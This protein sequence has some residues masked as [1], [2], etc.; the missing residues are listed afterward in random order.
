MSIL[1]VPH[2]AIIVVA[3][4][5]GTRLE[6][7]A[8]KA[9]V[10]IDGRT[11]LRHALDGVFA[12]AP[13]QVVVVAPAGYEGDAQTELLAAAGDRA[14]LGRVVTGGATRQES[15]AAGL[16]ALWGDVS[17]VLVHDAARA[18]TPP[19]VIDAVA[20]A[21]I[22]DAGA[23]PS[24]P[25]VDTLKRVADGL[26]VGTVDRAEL[27][28]AQTP[29]GFPRGPLEAAYAEA[30]AQGIE[31]TDDAALFAAAGHAVR[32]VPGSE[33]SFKITT[34]ADLE[35]AR[36]LV[37]SAPISSSVPRTSAVAVSAPRVGIG[38]DV[39]AFGGDGP[40]WLAGLEWP[41]EPALSGHSDGDA[42]AHAIVD[43]LLGAAG[44]GDIG[45]HFGTAHPEYAGAHADVFLSRT[46]ELLAEAG[47]M[48][49]NVSVQFQ[50]NRPRFSGR[51]G[52][53]EAALSAA[54]GG[55][56]VAVTA[57]TTDGLG[58][59]G[60]GEGIAVTAVAV[61]IPRPERSLSAPAE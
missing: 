25:V 31:Y 54:L 20:A 11:I 44:L 26:V 32:L 8:P 40:L 2:T 30:T 47:F 27:A 13:L 55:A 24:L 43:A 58:F 53:A 7:G 5:S 10:G 28:A 48:I 59:P 16:A 23:V 3:A 34:P 14:D 57:T 39:H 21:V 18:L 4:G 41:G 51:R 29:Q 15:V 22:A 36:L 19:E 1:P 46:A 42:V 38:T 60:R 56:P 33:R 35:R 61:V 12:A 50:G 37:A 9:F 49:G 45:E 6:A 52:E 17:T